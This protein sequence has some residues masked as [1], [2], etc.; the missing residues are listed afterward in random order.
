[1][2]LVQCFSNFN[3]KEKALTDLPGLM[4]SSIIILLLIYLVPIYSM[5]QNSTSLQ[6]IKVDQ[7]KIAKIT[8]GSDLKAAEK[9]FGKPD[10]IES[11]SSIGI[12]SVEE[13]LY[14][15][16]GVTALIANDKVSRLECVNPKYK[17][18]KGLKVGDPVEKVFKSLGKTQIWNIENHK[19]AQYA[20]WPPCDTYLIFEIEGEKVSKI[21]LDYIP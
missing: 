5:G 9:S 17:T 6:Y 13:Q 20:L 15:F 21:I 2:R 3:R 8:L 12:D 7:F 4:K 19:S 16:N 11:T 10:S 18:P 1:L 14:Y